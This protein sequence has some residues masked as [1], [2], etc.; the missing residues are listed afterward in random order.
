MANI[1]TPRSL[2][3]A[4]FNSEFGTNAQRIHDFLS[5]HSDGKATLAV[6]QKEVFRNNLPAADLRAAV[7]EPEKA[8][9]VRI[10]IK[11]ISKR[12]PKSLTT[13]EIRS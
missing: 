4:F 6:I 3:G 8:K 7:G 2:F 5:V 1:S 13:V 9:A 10:N 11:E 12:P